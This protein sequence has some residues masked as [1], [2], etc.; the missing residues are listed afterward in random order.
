MRNAIKKILL[1]VIT[2]MAMAMAWLWVDYSNFMHSPM[3]LSNDQ[4]IFMVEPGSNLSQIAI[5]LRDKGILSHPRYLRM[6]GRIEGNANRISVGEY[7]LEPGMTPAVFYQNLIA[8]KVIQHALTIVEGWTF[9]QMLEAIHAN[10]VLQATLKNSSAE[11]VMIAIGQEGQHPEGRFLPD[12]YHFTRGMTDVEFLKRA[13]QA[14]QDYLQQQWPQRSVGLPFNNSYEALI[15]ASIVEKETGKGS[16]RA[17][18]AGVFVRR[19]QQHIRLQTDPTVIYGMGDRYQ[20]NIQ[21]KDLLE[22]TPYNTYRRSGLTPTPI[23]LPGREAI[24]ASLHP[25]EGDDLYFVSKGDGSHYFSST[26]EQHN[27]AVIK[28][29]LNGRKRSFSSYKNKSE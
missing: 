11:Q 9:R 26:L 4:T 7:Q 15:L 10:P 1:F 29:Q 25:E 2:I 18:I 8:G 19:L 16:E 3:T 24:Y 12:T 27:Q 22:D 14:M 5:S 28:Y 20:G 6:Y 21:R 13:Y 17:A 23:A